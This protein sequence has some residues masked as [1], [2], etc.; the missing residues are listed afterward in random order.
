MN[1][2]RRQFLVQLSV[3]GGAALL[4]QVGARA[5]DPASVWVP[6]G[7]AKQFTKSDFTRVTLPK[8]QKE[9]VLWV[10][11]AADGSYLALSSRCTHKGCEVDWQKSDAQFVCPCHRGRFDAQGNNV[12]GPPPRPLPAFATR[13]E[14]DGTLSVQIPA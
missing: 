2:S 3:L 4:S 5:D 11:E 1:P 7:A 14:K 12:G 13:A 10:T 8:A 9:A 6:I